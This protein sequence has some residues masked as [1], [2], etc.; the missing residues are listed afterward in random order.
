MPKVITCSLVWSPELQRYA[1]FDGSVQLNII[2]ESHAW[3]DWLN[4]T[5]SFGFIHERVR[6]TLRKEKKQRGDAYWYA[7]HKD[8]EQLTKKYVG[9]TSDLTLTHLE[10]SITECDTP[11]HIPPESSPYPDPSQRAVEAQKVQHSVTQRTNDPLLAPKLHLPRLPARLVTRTRLLELLEQQ[12]IGPLTLISAQA[13]AG[14]TTLLAEWAAQHSSTVAWIS[15]DAEDNQPT[16]FLSYMIAA[17][18]TLDPM[19]GT[20]S[21]PPLKSFQP[22]AWEK[23]LALLANEISA[24]SVHPITLVLDDYHLITLDA[25]HSAIAFLLEHLTSHLHLII[26]TRSDPPLPLSRLRARGQLLELRISEL[27]FS[28]AETKQF[29]QTTVGRELKTEDVRLLEERTEGWIA[30]LQLAALSLRGKQDMSAFVYEFAGSN[31]FVLDYLSDEVLTHLPARTL[32]FLLHTCILERLYAPLC[33]ALLDEGEDLSTRDCQEMLETLEKANLFVSALDD[34]QHGF[35]YH[36]LFASV[37]QAHLTRSDPALLPHLHRRASIWFEQ[38]GSPYEAIYHALIIQDVARVTTLLQDIVWDMFLRGEFDILL[39]WLDRLPASLKYTRPV[40]YFYHATALASLGQWVAAEASLELV[41]KLQQ[42]QLASVETAH[43]IASANEIAAV[44]IIL[45]VTSG[46]LVQARAASQQIY[47]ELPANRIF[48]RSSLMGC[49]SIMAAID[50]DFRLA[51]QSLWQAKPDNGNMDNTFILQRGMLGLALC[52]THLGQRCQVVA[53]CEQGMNFTA[54]M[55]GT[56][57]IYTGTLAIFLSLVLYENNQLE[58]AR[59]R[60]QQGIE[61]CEQLGEISFVPMAHALLAQILHLEGSSVGHSASPSQEVLRYTQRA[62]TLLWQQS[63]L[64]LWSRQH[65]AYILVRLWIVQHNQEALARLA[66]FYPVDGE[67]GATPGSSYAA[68]TDT[69]GQAY[70]CFGQ[71]QFAK[72]IAWL[73]WPIQSAEQAG[74]MLAL[75]RMLILQ[76]AAYQELGQTTEAIG[77]LKRALK[78]AEPEGYITMF[79]EVGQTVVPLLLSLL[80]PAEE[81]SEISLTFVQTVL[82]ALGVEFEADQPSFNLS[83]EG[84]R[85]PTHISQ[86]PLTEREMEVLRLIGMGLSNQAIAH[87]MIV[88]VS[89]IK[90]HIRHIYAK[91]QVDNRTQALLSA[92]AHGLLP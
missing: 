11:G 33:S 74:R 13:G 27:R 78:Y 59:F 15:L 37:L 30:G 47:S 19:I 75:M 79:A 56:S 92:Q 63:P 66:Q 2:P 4:R 89:T 38:Q 87:Q 45:A 17:L 10:A 23:L 22:L 31:R 67:I 72:T 39:G 44:R 26:L 52:L 64:L 42:S 14:K 25:I 46:D 41:E 81:S 70:I 57:L 40:L 35:R 77:N 5:T 48:L 55:K 50:G 61:L 51:L 54:T 91:L 32:T 49:A 65:A 71:R 28:N 18:Q 21:L 43:V 12:A 88:E 90:W 9:K 8:G 7:Y 20:T 29:L 83:A 82:H 80:E 86:E 60:A 85:Q 53:I 34:N 24:S 68:Q 62:E 3:F 58:A 69:W 1:L 16:R 6:Y 36:A 84:N 76:A 73:H